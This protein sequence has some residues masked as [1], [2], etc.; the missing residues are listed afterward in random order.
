MTPHDCLDELASRLDLP[1]EALALDSS[2]HWSSWTTELD[3]AG[4]LTPS[5]KDVKT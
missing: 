5:R 2:N 3:E 4:R 1:A